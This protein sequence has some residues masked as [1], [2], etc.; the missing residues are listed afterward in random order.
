MTTVQEVTYEFDK[1]A[2]LYS[3]S[4]HSSKKRH[5]NTSP[6]EKSKGSAN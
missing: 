1:N 3:Y 6:H 5:A 2:V 4:G